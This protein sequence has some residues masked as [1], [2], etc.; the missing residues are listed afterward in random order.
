M[1]TTSPLNPADRMLDLVRK[2][3]ASPGANIDYHAGLAKRRTVAGRPWRGFADSHGEYCAPT[4][5]ELAPAVDDDGIP[6]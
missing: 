6:Y 4:P 5:A 1:N 3:A 2:L